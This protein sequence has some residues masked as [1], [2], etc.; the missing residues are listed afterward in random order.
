MPMKSEAVRSFVFAP[1]GSGRGCA[2]IELVAIFIANDN[3]IAINKKTSPSQVLRSEPL[4]M[5]ARPLD[6]AMVA[7]LW[8]PA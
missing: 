5:P 2:E 1:I 3:I 4:V 7:L 8:V 6:E